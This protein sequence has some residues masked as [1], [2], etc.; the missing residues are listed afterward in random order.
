MAGSIIKKLEQ[1]EKALDPKKLASEAYRVFRAET[2][3]RSGNARR[4]TQLAQDEIQASYPYAGRLD[5]GYSRQS[6]RGMTEPT[7]KFI[8]E[9]I[10]KQGN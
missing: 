6:P 10:D 5:Q 3:V 4:N 2:P 9:Y 8:Q 7:E 1:L